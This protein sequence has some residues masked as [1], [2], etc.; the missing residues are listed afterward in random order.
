MCFYNIDAKTSVIWKKNIKNFPLHLYWGR[1]IKGDGL[2]QSRIRIGS[3]VF[4]TSSQVYMLTL[5]EGKISGMY[6]RNIGYHNNFS[7]HQLFLENYYF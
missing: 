4:V 2:E 1:G 6:S 3:T 5:K 7:N